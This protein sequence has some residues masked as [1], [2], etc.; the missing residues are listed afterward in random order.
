[1]TATVCLAGA[2]TVAVVAL[3]AA[4]LR[5]RRVPVLVAKPLASVSF[6]L[7][8]WL[9]YRPGHPYDAWVLLA[10]LLCLFGDVMLMFRRA[11]VAGLASFLLGHVA[12]T[13]A[14]SGL[15]PPRSWPPGWAMPMLLVSL[16]AARWLWPHLGRLRYAVLAYVAVITVMVWGAVAVAATGRGPWFLGA[17]GV[18][19]YLSD[20]AVARD[21]FVA[22]R[23]ASR[24]W[25]L[26]AYYLAQLLLALTVG[27]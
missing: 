11:F 7:I 12:Y 13:V 18:L 24:A 9:R 26:P 8:A 5:G 22:G 15:L 19:F 21:R 2:M 3:V 20:L 16:V 6:L 4:E 25:G 27:R 17:G 1:M 23:F 10:L 14:F